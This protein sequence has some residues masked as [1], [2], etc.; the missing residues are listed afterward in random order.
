MRYEDFQF[1]RFA[2]HEHGVL[3]ATLN[4][5]DVMNATN[6][7]LHWELTKVWGV[8]QEDPAAQGLEPAVAAWAAVYAH[9]AAGDLAA[10]SRGQ[11]G[12][13]ARDLLEGLCELWVEWKR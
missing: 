4:R 12:L 5:P 7:R 10:R 11:A 3:L 8:F 13:L 2:R 9:G 6:A 1:I